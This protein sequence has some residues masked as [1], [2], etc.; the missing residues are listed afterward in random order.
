VAGDPDEFVERITKRVERRA[1][2]RREGHANVWFG[3]STFGIVGW[4]IAVPT[5]IG[6]AIGVWLDRHVHTHFSWTLALLMAGITLG[7]LNAGYWVS[8]QRIT[9]EDEPEEEP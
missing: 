8:Q 1:R 7:C 2:R 3:V 5:V 9:D 6:L 4:S